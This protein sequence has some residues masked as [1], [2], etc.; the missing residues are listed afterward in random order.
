MRGDLVAAMACAAGEDRDDGR[1]GEHRETQWPLGQVRGLAEE[2]DAARSNPGGNAVDLYRD[3]APLSQAPHEG[4]PGERFR[5]DVRHVNPVPLSGLVLDG[6]GLRIV[7]GPLGHQETQPATAS[8][9]RSDDLPTGGMGRHEQ[10][11]P[12][13]RQRIVDVGLPGYDHLRGLS[14][15]YARAESLGETRS[16]GCK[17][18]RD[19]DSVSNYAAPA[20][21]SAQIADNRAPWSVR[22]RGKGHADNGR[23][24]PGEPCRAPRPEAS[25][26]SPERA[27][28]RQS[29][30]A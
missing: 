22:E 23:R 6:P 4:K 12:L 10:Q 11:T 18:P 27:V 30:H 16:V 24:P 26:L 19:I 20:A 3:G 25:P 17:R 2:G 28:E 8:D 29:A 15:L 7:L 21:Y 13:V 14:P 9:Q 5:T 1:S